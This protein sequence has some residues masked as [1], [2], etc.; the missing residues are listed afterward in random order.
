MT[1]Q[2]KEIIKRIDMIEAF[3]GVDRS[4][5]GY[6]PAG[7]YDPLYT[8]IYGLYQELAFLRKFKNVED[9]FCDRLALN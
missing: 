9:M 7:R 4:I 2:K 1:R 5:C 3:I 8:E 6:A